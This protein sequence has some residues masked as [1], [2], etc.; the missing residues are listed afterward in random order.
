MC[1]FLIYWRPHIM[2]SLTCVN[3]FQIFLENAT[4]IYCELIFWLEA[5]FVCFIFMNRV[6]C[7]NYVVCFMNKPFCLIKLCL[8]MR[9]VWWLISLVHIHL[10]AVGCSILFWIRNR[11][12]E[13][14]YVVGC[15]S[16]VLRCNAFMEMKFRLTRY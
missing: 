7:V 14:V 13:S 3:W 15:K 16:E 6:T 9:L 5:S 11:R 4:I 10:P 2:L 1:Y 8:W 12:R